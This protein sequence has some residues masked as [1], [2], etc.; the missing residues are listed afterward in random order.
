MDKTVHHILCK[1]KVLNKIETG[2]N[3]V[4]DDINFKIY[5]CKRNSWD[6]FLKWW[7]G[8]DRYTTANKLEGFYLEIKDLITALLTDTNANKTNIQRLSNELNN[9]FVGIDNLMITYQH[10]KTIISQLE[11]VKENFKLELSR[12]TDNNHDNLLTI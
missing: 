8:E 7:L 12:L 11:T 2:Q 10:D 3:L 9:S 1:L 5:D 4:I 6:R